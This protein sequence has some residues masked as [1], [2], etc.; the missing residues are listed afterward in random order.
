MNPKNPRP[1]FELKPF[2]YFIMDI[3]DIF[4]LSQ[5]VLIGFWSQ[6]YWKELSNYIMNFEIRFSSSW[7]NLK[8]FTIS[9]IPLFMLNIILL[10]KVSTWFNYC[11]GK[12]DAIDKHHFHT[13]HFFFTYIKLI[14]YFF[15]FILKFSSFWKSDKLIFI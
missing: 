12:H 13:H 7:S 11:N 5:E 4:K 1:S 15:F 9:I 8:L 3:V 6:T 10:F 2:F 14:Q